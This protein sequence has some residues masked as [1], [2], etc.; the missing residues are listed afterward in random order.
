MMYST[1]LSEKLSSQLKISSIG[2]FSKVHFPWHQVRSGSE[3]S[4]VFVV[5]NLVGVV[6]DVL[7]LLLTIPGCEKMT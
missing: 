3:G 6:N 2:H 4:K 1:V 5:S 7:V